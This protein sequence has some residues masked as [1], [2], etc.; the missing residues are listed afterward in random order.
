MRTLNEY[1]YDECVDDR[2]FTQKVKDWFLAKKI[3]M[4]MWF[5]AHPRETFAIIAVMASGA[6]KIIPK[7]LRAR[8]I[9][10]QER[11]KEEYVYD[12]SLGHYWKLKR[13]LDNDEWREIEERKRNGERLGDI[14]EELKV[15]A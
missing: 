8:N 3:A 12:R 11:I 1:V 15:L 7:L 13:P 4:K 9:N 5:E 6:V 10:E 2:K 14:L